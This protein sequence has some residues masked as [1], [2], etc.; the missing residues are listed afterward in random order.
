MR[1]ENPELGK[2]ARPDPN[3]GPP[4]IGNLEV[5]AVIQCFDG[6]GRVLDD[7]HLSIKAGE[8]VSLVGP[9]GCGKTSLLRIIAGLDSPTAG[10]VSL[11]GCDLTGVPANK[12]SIHTVFQSYALFPHLTVEENVAFGLRM[13]GSGLGSRSEA[14]QRALEIGRISE[15]AKRR[16]DQLS[17]GQRQRVALVRALINKPAVV[18]LDEPMAAIDQQLRKQLRE[19]LR[20]MQKRLGTTFICVTHDQE[21]AF[22]ISDRV[23]VMKLGKVMQVGTPAEIYYH[24]ASLFV[25]RFLGE[26]NVLSAQ[27]AAA[28]G[29]GGVFETPLGLLTI[30]APVPVSGNLALV[31]RPEEIEAIDLGEPE[32]VEA[33]VESFVFTGPACIARLKAETHRETILVNIPTKRGME[34]KLKDR[35]RIRVKRG[36]GQLLPAP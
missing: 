4:V 10:T 24:P 17:G 33:V 12:R 9:S 8:F 19:E 36:S 18:L 5:K 26:C 16:P 34:L 20:A 22:A 23:V 27:P 28:A 1:D 30:E 3:D 21:E 11:D 29:L 13:K 35:L 14:V 31:L 15:L 25:A 7:V 6:A 2:A 32:G